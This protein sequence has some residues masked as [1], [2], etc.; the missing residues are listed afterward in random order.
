MTVRIASDQAVDVVDVVLEDVPPTLRAVGEEI[1]GKG[2]LDE[3]GQHDDTDLRR[4]AA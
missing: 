1:E 3:L 2:G 4:R